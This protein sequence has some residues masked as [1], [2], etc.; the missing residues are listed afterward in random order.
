MTDK[1]LLGFD[2]GEKRIG[3]AVGQT[4]TRSANPL[5]ILSSRQ[6]RPDWLRIGQLIQQWQPSALIVGHPLTM[7][8]QRQAMTD[9]CERFARQLNGRFQLPVHLVDERLSSHE[10]E[11]RLQRDDNIDAV[12]AQVILETWFSQ[13]DNVQ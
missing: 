11:Q 5:E 13:Q 12:A 2:F 10:A 4:V 1:T 3:V 7:Q 8:Q 6:N 9:R